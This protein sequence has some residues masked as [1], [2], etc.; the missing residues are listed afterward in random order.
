M[1]ALAYKSETVSPSLQYKEIPATEDENNFKDSIEISKARIDSF[2]KTP[3]VESELEENTDSNTVVPSL[4]KK[5]NFV[6]FVKDSLVRQKT[7]VSSQ[8]WKGY[9]TKREEDYFSAIITDP[10]NENQDEE[11]QMP[12]KSISS[13]DLHLVVEGSYFDWHIGYEKISGTTQRFSK[14]LFRRMPKWTSDDFN[15]AKHLA[16][17]IKDFLSSQPE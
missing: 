7:S 1:T 14:V 6:E 11:I 13:D 3:S 15:K 17:Q 5:E 10:S 2:F 16:Q 8:H 9:V 12:L 4:S